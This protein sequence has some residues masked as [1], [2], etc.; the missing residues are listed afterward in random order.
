MPRMGRAINPFALT[1]LALLPALPA[2]PLNVV[3]ACPLEGC[4]CSCHPPYRC[5]PRSG[6]A[7]ARACTNMSAQASQTQTGTDGHVGLVAR[8][9]TNTSTNASQT[10]ARMQHKPLSWRL[11]GGLRVLSSGMLGG[12][13]F[14]SW[15]CPEQGSHT[16]VLDGSLFEEEQGGH[17]F[18]HGPYGAATLG[19]S[20]RSQRRRRPNTVHPSRVME[21]MSCRSGACRLDALCHAPARLLSCPWACPVLVSKKLFV[22][23][24]RHLVKTYFK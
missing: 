3:A 23:R 12:S 19:G 5:L 22:R 18:L 1:S 20:N 2:A 21:P 17:T 6:K 13:L 7:A 4:G 16:A 15:T 8:A 24:T 9:C 14:C 11:P 10:Q